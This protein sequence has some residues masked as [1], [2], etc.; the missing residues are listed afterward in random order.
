[1]TENS[2]DICILCCYA[3][4]DEA[5]QSELVKHTSILRRQRLI[6]TWYDC[7]IERAEN[8]REVVVSQLGQADIILLLI[9][10]DFLATDFYTNT[11]MRPVLGMRQIGRSYALPII[12]R[13]IDPTAWEHLL[14]RNP[15][16]LLPD[17]KAV[18]DWPDSDEAF[19]KV[20]EVLHNMINKCLSNQWYAEGQALQ[21]QKY[22]EEALVAFER[23][24]ELAPANVHAYRSRIQTLV[25]LAMYEEALAACSKALNPDAENSDIYFLQGKIL[26][27]LKRYKEA[28]SAFERVDPERVGQLT[29]PT[30]EGSS[31]CQC[32]RCLLLI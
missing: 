20:T 7:Q 11:E 15:N 6:T 2:K 21:K 17:G 8:T 31:V 24:I 10:P 19:C 28:F 12:I 23:A 18:T 16:V 30:S 32:T 25:C 29:P 9:S 5:L 4:K 27:D 26:L 13:S 3:Q 1:M 14:S 22:Y